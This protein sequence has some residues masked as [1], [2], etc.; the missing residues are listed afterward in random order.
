VAFPTASGIAR[1]SSCMVEVGKNSAPD[2]RIDNV[3]ALFVWS[4]GVLL[5]LMI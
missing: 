3:V 2:S 1:N 5:F 4:I